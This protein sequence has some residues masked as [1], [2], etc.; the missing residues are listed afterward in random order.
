MKKESSANKGTALPAERRKLKRVALFIE[1]SSAYGRDILMG[2]NEYMR[3]HQPW[4]VY[5][6]HSDFESKPLHWV[7]SAPWDG[8]LSRLTDPEVCR[9][10]RD[11]HIPVV[12]LNDL[13]TELGFPWIGSDHFA[14]GKLAADTLF[15]RGLRRFAFCGFSKTLWS[16]NRKAGFLSAIESHGCSVKVYEVPSRSYY[17]RRQDTNVREFKKWLSSLQKPVG[18]MASNDVRAV[19]LLDAC[20]QAGIVVPDEVA[21]IGVDNEDILC[22][23]CLPP[24]SSVVPSTSQIGYQAARL[25]DDLMSGA[26]STPL[27]ILI[28][29]KGIVERL[30]SDTLAINDQLVRESVIFIREN[31]RLGCRVTDLLKKFSISRTA[32][33]IRFK[34]AIGRSPSKVILSQKI[35]T[36]Q[37]LLLESDYTLEK[38]SEVTGFKYHEHMNTAFKRE[39]GITPAAWKKVRRFSRLPA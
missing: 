27:R 21:V 24:L 10:F 20:Y 19:H 37:S 17:N 7:T 39:V 34:N 3:T 25:L 1:T 26:K 15:E 33:E 9:S 5:L 18:I 22:N 28:P 13:T 11:R 32:L 29:P 23:V 4:S 14:I 16:D 6:D 2:I 12:D 8:I 38:I 35:R 36:V 30:S 31:A